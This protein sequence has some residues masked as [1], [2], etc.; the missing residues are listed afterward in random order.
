MPPDYPSWW[1][2]RIEAW[3]HAH[4]DILRDKFNIRSPSDLT[5]DLVWELGYGHLLVDPP[6][7]KIKVAVAIK[8]DTIWLS[9]HAPHD[10]A[11]VEVV[12]SML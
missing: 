3:F 8:P 10:G 5:P 12:L 9:F 4:A 1:N 11:A 2:D 6:K 7:K